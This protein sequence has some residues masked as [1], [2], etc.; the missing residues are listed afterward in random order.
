MHIILTFMNVHGGLQRP[1]D[2]VMYRNV[3][4]SL[5]VIIDEDIVSVQVSGNHQVLY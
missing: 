2:D 5:Y 4:Y 1:L 3:L